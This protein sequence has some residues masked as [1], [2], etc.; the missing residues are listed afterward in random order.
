MVQ[1]HLIESSN[2][3][4]AKVPNALSTCTIYSVLD[5]YKKYI[6]TSTLIGNKHKCMIKYIHN[7]SHAGLRH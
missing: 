6:K 7:Q 4:A 2:Q 3:K 1:V 5:R